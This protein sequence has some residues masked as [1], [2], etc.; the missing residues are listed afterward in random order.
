MNRVV[1]KPIFGMN[2]NEQ[3]VPTGPEFFDPKCDLFKRIS[4]M[5]EG[6]PVSLAEGWALMQEE[7]FTYA[8]HL[9]DFPKVTE[10][11]SFDHWTLYLAKMGYQ[12]ILN[13]NEYLER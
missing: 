2:M 12:I 10:I 1:F 6:K 9:K 4:S 13:G 7:F 3:L 8:F 5:P 11:L